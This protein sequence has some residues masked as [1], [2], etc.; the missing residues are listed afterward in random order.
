MYKRKLIFAHSLETEAELNSEKAYFTP[1]HMI[2]HTLAQTEVTS[3]RILASNHWRT[4][5]QSIK[6]NGYKT[7]QTS[8]G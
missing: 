6:G 7:R 8:K 4:T 5:T 3:P 1:H 2:T